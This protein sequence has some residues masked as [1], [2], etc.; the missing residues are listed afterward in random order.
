MLCLRLSLKSGECATPTAS[1]QVG[2][3]TGR[4][5]FLDDAIAS[6]AT[7][8]VVDATGAEAGVGFVLPTRTSTIGDSFDPAYEMCLVW[9]EGGTGFV[10][11]GAW[12][13]RGLNRFRSSPFV[14]EV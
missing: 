12:G 7:A 4:G 5:A 14:P 8:R 2:D 6:V 10:T 1:G 11:G 13:G 9:P 3:T